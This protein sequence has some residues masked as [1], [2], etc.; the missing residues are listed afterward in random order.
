MWGF[1]V[2]VGLGLVALGLWARARGRGDGEPSH[3]W[4]PVLLGFASLCVSTTQWLRP[5][6]GDETLL[7]AFLAIGALLVYMIA[8]GR[9]KP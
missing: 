4:I 6:W 8:R 2:G 5:D 3:W 9:L 7:G 1:Q